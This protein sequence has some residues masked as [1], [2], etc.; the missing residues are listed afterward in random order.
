MAVDRK[1]NI[2]CGRHHRNEIMGTKWQLLIRWSDRCEK[3]LLD[4]DKQEKYNE[5]NTHSLEE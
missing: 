3:I 4:H 1:F 2:R 5:K